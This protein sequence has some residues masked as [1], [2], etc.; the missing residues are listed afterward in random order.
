MNIN[1]ISN[2]QVQFSSRNYPIAP[3]TIQTSSDPLFVEELSKADYH[4][5]ADFSFNCG[6]EAFPD[7]AEDWKN[8][9]VKEKIA[10]VKNGEKLYIE[11]MNKKD[12]N[13]TVLVGK[14]PK[15]D[16]K[17]LF[18]M[19]NF[20]EFRWLKE[21]FKDVKTGFVEECM[22]DAKYRGQGI[23]KVIFDK[24][25]KSADGHFTDIFL[26]ADN[27]AINFYTRA[28]FS[29]LDTSNPLIKKISDYI[30]MHRKDRDLIT[31]MSKSLDQSNPW[32]ARIAK[33]LK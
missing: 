14:D 28:G 25:L 18:S 22:I 3:F 1:K 27:N 23:G 33:H 29:P 8:S 9:T 13:S 31:L 10:R 12:G 7:W 4:K 19:Q 5:A 6:L 21:K 2:N 20:D 15:N 24:I 16:I 17:A 11:I 30:L 32:W 26:E